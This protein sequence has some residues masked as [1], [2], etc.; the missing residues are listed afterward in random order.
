[1][2]SVWVERKP[3][4]VEQ[5]VGGFRYGVRNAEGRFVT[6]SQGLAIEDVTVSEAI[7][8][9]LGPL[10]GVNGAEAMS[11]LQAVRSDDPRVMGAVADTVNALNDCKNRIRL[12][13]DR[14]E[15]QVQRALDLAEVE[16][17]AM[18]VRVRQDLK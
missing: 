4:E 12:R 17:H 13:Q 7:Y 11:A 8:A 14:A 16:L 6:D 15:R 3:G 1:M 10:D 5:H 18:T 9:A 2:V